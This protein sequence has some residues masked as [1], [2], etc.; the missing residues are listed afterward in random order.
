MRTR[1]NITKLVRKPW[2]GQMTEYMLSC[3]IS[4]WYSLHDGRTLWSIVDNSMTWTRTPQGEDYW[5]TIYSNLRR[6]NE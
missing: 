4:R 6:N 2:T 5:R 3:N 1:E